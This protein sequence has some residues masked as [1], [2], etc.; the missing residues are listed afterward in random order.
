M[1]EIIAV[2]SRQQAS[3]NTKYY[4][5]Y[6]YFIRRHT[7]SSIAL[8]FNKRISTITRWINRY[9]QTGNVAR[10]RTMPSYRRFNHMHREWILDLYRRKP[11]M[12]LDECAYEFLKHF[13]ISISIKSVWQILIVNGL[14]RK[15]IERRA[16]NIQEKDIIRYF[17]EINSI[18]WVTSNLVFLDEVS[19]DNRDMLRK[20]GY[21]IKGEALYYRGEFNRRPRV[22][23]L[24]FLG[25]KGFL[26]VYNTEGTFTRSKFI[27]KCREF[28][29]DSGKVLK[30]PGFNSVWILDGAKIHCHRKLIYYLRT[31]GIII[32]FLPAYCPFFNPIEILFGFVK[33]RFQR[34]Y[35]ECSK[36][37]LLLTIGKAF[38]PFYDYNCLNI[39]KHCGYSESSN[40]EPGKALSSATSRNLKKF[41]EFE[42]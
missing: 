16:I 13:K 41:M 37:P 18:D 39:F 26:G 2:T 32:I 27:E 30:Y 1:D 38:K 24:C 25:E 14:S 8:M 11:L 28:I 19:F 40:F 21:C 7:K 22:S 29:L 6:N 10:I 36:E 31:L 3:D 33:K 35:S 12:F 5:L 4:A 9:S 42:N 15:I 34:V 20:Y 17:R 23:L